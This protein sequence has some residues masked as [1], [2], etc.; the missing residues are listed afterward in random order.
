MIRN[1]S[2]FSFPVQR[3]QY[4]CR[5]QTSMRN[6]TER[7]MFNMSAKNFFTQKSNSKQSNAVISGGIRRSK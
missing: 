7:D 4:E 5:T 1:K 2:D 6:S 3:S